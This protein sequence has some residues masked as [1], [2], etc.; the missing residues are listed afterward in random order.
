MI[1][2]SLGPISYRFRDM[3]IFPLINADFFYF[4]LFNFNF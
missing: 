4:F 1:N 3:V 2:S